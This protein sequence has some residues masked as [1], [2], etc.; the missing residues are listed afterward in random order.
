MSFVIYVRAYSGPCS[1][2]ILLRGT[3]KR[4][5]LDWRMFVGWFGAISGII[6]ARRQ[7]VWPPNGRQWTL[8]G[9][10]RVQRVP[11]AALI[12]KLAIDRPLPPIAV[13]API[14]L[15]II[16]FPEN[17]N[18]LGASED[19]TEALCVFNSSWVL[20]WLSV[21]AEQFLMVFQWWKCRN[22]GWS[23]PPATRPVSRHGTP[24]TTPLSQATLA[25]TIN[26]QSLT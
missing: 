21:I 4:Q 22:T 11:T 12:R 20:V 19:V 8:P 16:D 9:I 1:D 13:L 3:E 10:D 17:G 25:P 14:S 15:W 23:V 7:D 5:C 26:F 2:K 6:V 24:S 18:S